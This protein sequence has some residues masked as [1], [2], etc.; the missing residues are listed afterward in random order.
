MCKLKYLH[1][2]FKTFFESKELLKA[3]NDQVSEEV[4][5]VKPNTDYIMSEQTNMSPSL[6]TRMTGMVDYAYWWEYARKHA[7]PTP[8]G[9]RQGRI[10]A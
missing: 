9:V 8:T 10:W 3:S 4:P 6:P 7:K 1:R 5:K 2:S